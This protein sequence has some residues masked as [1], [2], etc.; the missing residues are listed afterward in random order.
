VESSTG[1]QAAGIGRPSKSLIHHRDGRRI[2]EGDRSRAQPLEAVSEVAKPPAMV[3]PHSDRRVEQLSFTI[4]ISLRQPA[5]HARLIPNQLMHKGNDR[6]DR[7]RVQNEVAALSALELRAGRTLPDGE[8]A[9]MRARL[10]EFADIL[11]AWDRRVT[12]SQRGN[13]EVLC[14]P[15]P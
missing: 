13:V 5:G 11:R 10:L 1:W 7:S 14:Q 6:D 3:G 9:A 15:E 8:W 2:L 12:P 4:S